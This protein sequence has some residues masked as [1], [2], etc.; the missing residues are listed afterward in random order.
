MQ[1]KQ[2][3]VLWMGLILVLLRGFTNGQF[4]LL[5]GTVET[6]TAASKTKTSSTTATNSTSESGYTGAVTAV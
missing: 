1:N 3:A 5:W 6:P 2:T 4:S